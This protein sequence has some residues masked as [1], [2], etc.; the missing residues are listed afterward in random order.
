[1]T[2][3]V[4]LGLDLQ[5]LP[6]KA[7]AKVPLRAGQDSDQYREPV[8]A[9]YAKLLKT[10]QSPMTGNG[11]RYKTY[12]EET[13]SQRL[14]THIDA[15]INVCNGT[16]GHNFLHGTSVFAGSIAAMNLLKLSLADAGVP[17][18]A[19]RQIGTHDCE[20]KGVAITYL[21]E[22]ESESA[23]DK[24]SKWLDRNAEILH[25]KRR[26]QRAS[27]NVTTYVHHRDY[28]VA[29]YNKTDFSHGYVPDAAY[30][31]HIKARSR[32]Y[33]RIEVYLKPALLRDRGWHLIESWR[34]AYQK[35]RYEAIFNEF[36][37]GTY[38]L[39]EN[40]RH[41]RPRREVVESLPPTARRLLE[42]YLSG[43]NA[44]LFKSIARGTD[45]TA[46]NKLRSKWRLLILRTAKVDIDIPWC[47]HQE[48]RNYELSRVLSYPGDHHPPAEY[49][50][51]CFCKASW[52]TWLS[53][54]LKKLDEY[55]ATA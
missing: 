5:K 42:G 3:T 6:P 1:M 17:V 14:A 16:V 4:H 53:A 8:S 13:D 20:L 27:S 7:R 12:W 40:L 45:K 36:V 47:Q 25:S 21:I 23:A 32:C 30:T 19:L 39:D 31:E 2:D 35:G 10:V 46:Q 49:C 24:L 37:R 48:L 43:K 55:E 38:R 50:G 44:R 15:W 28:Y 18:S 29:S 11:M 51:Q 22:C 9:P 34:H 52:P 33:V 41:K 26:E 54:M